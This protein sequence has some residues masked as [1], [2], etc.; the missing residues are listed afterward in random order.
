MKA[1]KKILALLITI[2]M[3]LPFAVACGGSDN[4]DHDNEIICNKCGEIVLG[5]SYYS[6]MVKL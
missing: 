1:L 3:V 2:C 5:D 4:C 6:N